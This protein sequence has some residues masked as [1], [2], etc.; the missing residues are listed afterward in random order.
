MLV[1]SV[2][3]KKAFDSVWHDGLLNK[4]LQIDVGGSFYN[5]IESLYHNSSCSKLPQNKRVS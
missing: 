2:D 3:F 5:L 4:P 1:F